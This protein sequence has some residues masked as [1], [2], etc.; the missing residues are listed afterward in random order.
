MDYSPVFTSELEHEYNFEGDFINIYGP[1]GCG[2]STIVKLYFK[3]KNYVYLDD[4]N[5]SLENFLNLIKKVNKIDIMSYFLNSEE[6]TT[7]I[8]DN[9]DNYSYKYDDYSKYLRGFKVIIISINKYFKNAVYIPPPS[10]LYLLN[11]LYCI[12]S[13][14]NKN[15][16]KVNIEGSFHK[17]YSSLSNNDFIEFDEYYS[18]L[19]CLKQIFDTKNYN[20]TDYNIKDFHTSYIYYTKNFKKLENIIEHIST[21]IL[22]LNTEYYSYINNMLVCRL[23]SEIFKI[24]KEKINYVKKNNTIKECKIYGITPEELS[25]IKL[26]KKY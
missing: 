11:V 25:L 12:N 4:Y 17:F 2:K 5:L 18:D 1:S 7:I 23:D 26:I 24:Y 13:I 15:Y 21:S 19:N 9:Y 20:L 16:K 6:H 3:D 14:E 10:E 8:I 22:F